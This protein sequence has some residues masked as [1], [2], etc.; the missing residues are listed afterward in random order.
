MLASAAL[1]TLFSDTTAPTLRPC[2]PTSPLSELASASLTLLIAEAS[3]ASAV[4]LTS[5][6]PLALTVVSRIFAVA[7]EPVF[8]PNA[9][10]IAGSPIS[11]S[12]V[13]NRM[14]C[15]C[16]P[17][18]L[19]ASVTATPVSPDATTLSTVASIVASFAALTVTSLPAPVVVTALFDSVAVAP[20]S[21]RLV[22]ISPP[23]ASESPAPKSPAP[24]SFCSSL[25]SSAVS[26]ADVVAVTLISPP[27]LSVALS[28][29]AVAPPRTSLSDTAPETANDVPS[30]NGL[31][32]TADE[33]VASVVVAAISAASSAD[34]VTPAAALIVFAPA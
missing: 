12:I 31:P 17:I 33:R 14:F 1:D 2:P 15:D 23:A 27:A 34:T 24:P 29:V 13:L 18:V 5:T 25:V 26:V 16:Q 9:S 21:T 8:A 10:A 4:A 30:A 32:V 7:P 3:V 6:A 19:N 11:A 22:A 28:I 20:A